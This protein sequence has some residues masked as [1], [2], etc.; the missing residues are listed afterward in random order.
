MSC[1]IQF[2]FWDKKHCVV[3][4]PVFRIIDL[5]LTIAIFPALSFSCENRPGTTDKSDVRRVVR[6]MLNRTVG[7]RMISKQECICLLLGNSLVSCSEIIDTVSISRS[8]RITLKKCTMSGANVLQKYAKRHAAFESYSLHSY[9]HYLENKQKK[10]KKLVVPHYVGGNM[11]MTF[12]MRKEYATSMLQIYKPWR[13]PIQI[14][15]ENCT[16]FDSFVHSNSCPKYLSM[17]SIRSIRKYTSPDSVKEPVSSSVPRHL[18][19]NPELQ[20]YIDLMGKHSPNGVDHDCGYNYDL[21][22]EYDWAKPVNTSVSSNRIS[23]QRRV[24]PNITSQLPNGT[25]W[26]CDSISAI[27]ES[28]ASNTNDLML[29]TKTDGTFYELEDLK[30]YRDQYKAVMKILAHLK[31][32]IEGTPQEINSKPLRTM[33]IGSGQYTQHAIGQNTSRCILSHELTTETNKFIL[34]FRNQSR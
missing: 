26:L 16:L 19:T 33:L 2:V 1:F 11:N 7:N 31:K 22:L 23:G 6:R 15:Q 18:P 25:T 10:L 5:Y 20:E 14:S 34:D 9:F 32:W 17:L 8:S 21:G 30:P 3:F 12:P 28:N 24:S 4:C 27:E 13:E 29:P